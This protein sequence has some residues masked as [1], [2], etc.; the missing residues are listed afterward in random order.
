MDLSRFTPEQ[1][2]ELKSALGMATDGSGRSPFP[3]RQL[4]DLRLLPTKDDPR[5]TFFWSAESPRG[6]DLT[7]TFPYPRLLWSQDGV[8]VVAENATQHHAFLEDGY[9]ET[10][11]AMAAIDPMA[12]LQAELDA[13]TPDDRALVLEAQRQDRLKA[14]HTKLAGLS[15]AS[16]LTLTASP[17]ERI[18]KRKPGRPRK[19]A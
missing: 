8:E 1:I 12:E 9:V 5:P 2:A 4:D 14:L 10:A 16:L 7:K 13:L 18:E 3:K 11:P 15:D 19:S 6:V 17:E